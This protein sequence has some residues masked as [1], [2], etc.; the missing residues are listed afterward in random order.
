MGEEDQPGEEPWKKKKNQNTATKSERSVNSKCQ[1]TLF[2]TYHRDLKQIYPL[3]VFN[4]YLWMLHILYIKWM[5]EK[6]DSVFLLIRKW[7]AA[8]AVWKA[9]RSLDFTTNQC[10]H[11]LVCEKKKS[12]IQILN[13]ATLCLICWFC[14]D[15]LFCL[16]LDDLVNSAFKNIVALLNRP[17]LTPELLAP[18]LQ[19]K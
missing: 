19:P 12:V 7:F 6:Y 3:K 9:S 16:P 5:C 2:L 11:A 14:C 18:H 15:L 1:E 10:L 4:H 17:Q 13:Y 8:S